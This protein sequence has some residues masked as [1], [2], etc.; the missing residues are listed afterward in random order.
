MIRAANKFDLLYFL[1]SIHDLN[2]G[3]NLWSGT[4]IDDEYI[5]SLFLTL[6]N[7]GGIVLVAENDKEYLGIIAGIITPFLWDPKRYVLQ[8]IVF[9]TNKERANYKRVAYELIKAYKNAGD[10]LM[11]KN[12]IFNHTFNTSEPMF[13]VD[14]AKYDYKLVEQIWIGV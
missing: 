11:K 9:N 12:R 13:N 1:D 5:N 14:L 7:G 3:H 4:T 2:D 8:H 10:E 6:I